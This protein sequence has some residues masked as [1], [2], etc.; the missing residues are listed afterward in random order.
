MQ[1]NGPASTP[2]M[3]P[4]LKAALCPL[5][6]ELVAQ[7]PKVDTDTQRSESL[8]SCRELTFQN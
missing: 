8:L 3:Q 1:Y 4:C 2:N 6:A 7:G 5:A